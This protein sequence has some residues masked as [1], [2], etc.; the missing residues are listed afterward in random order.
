MSVAKQRLSPSH[1][2]RINIYQHSLMIWFR[3]ILF[4]LA[5]KAVARSTSLPA[6]ECSPLRVQ[7]PSFSDVEVLS[8]MVFPVYDHE[9]DAIEVN[10]IK[11]RRVSVTFCNFS[12]TYTH[13][14]WDD[15]I[16]MQVWLPLSDWNKR[17]Q[18]IG[19]VGW[20]GT[21]GDSATALA[22]SEGYVA[23]SSDLGHDAT[24]PSARD[25]ALDETS[26]HVNLARLLDFSYVGLLDMSRLAKDVAQ[27]LYGEVP[28]HSYWN[29]CGA[30]GRQ[31]MM[32]AQRFPEAFDGIV[33]GSPTLSW[34]H[35]MPT[36][37]WPT[38][39]MKMLNTYP[40]S[41]VM[42]AIAAEA[43]KAC[44]DR[45]GVVE[46]IITQ[47]ERC[48]FNPLSLVGKNADC[49]DGVNVEITLDVAILV[50]KIWQG[51]RSQDGKPLW[52]GFSRGSLWHATRCSS[53]GE[54]H[55]HTCTPAPSTLVLDWLELFVAQNP[56]LELPHLKLTYP[57]FEALFHLS[58]AA[59]QSI[60]SADSPDL[61]DFK[62]RGG[63]IIHWHG[64]ND[65][66]VPPGGSAAYYVTVKNRDPSVMDFYRYFEAPGVGHCGS[67]PGAAPIGVMGA[68]TIWVE[69]GIAP[70]IL[71][72]VSEDGS[73]TR[74]LC[75]FP[76][77]VTYL[78]GDAEKPEAFGCRESPLWR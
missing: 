17:L 52:Y 28:K 72:A 22:V 61:A 74:I 33:V 23:V 35:F 71:P 63:K 27:Q 9:I 4:L 44:D 58:I 45:D 12:L 39:V 30:G 24:K 1:L 6:V 46:G 13:P 18:G 70:D 37:Y 47:P 15:V 60:I 19:G 59:Y 41:C 5:I 10:P 75:P 2:R 31:G 73:L 66:E 43:V 53:M 11:H 76:S 26:R 78:E 65:G 55:H 57:E 77:V 3:F 29:G 20:A 36:G 50:E 62:S 48:D 8:Y 69:T 32:L 38:F 68:L 56:D 21:R 67:G 7:P 51:M 49:G 54:V 40:S 16:N 25:W 42:D 14:G 34:A 64:L